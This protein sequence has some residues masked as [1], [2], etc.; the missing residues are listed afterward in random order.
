MTERRLRIAV[1][2][3]LAVH[4]LLLSASRPPIARMDESSSPLIARLVRLPNA[5]VPA[6]PNPTPGVRTSPARLPRHEDRPADSRVPASTRDVIATVFP[7]ATRLGATT[8]A[9]VTPATSDDASTASTRSFESGPEVPARV[10]MV[11]PATGGAVSTSVSTEVK[12]GAVGDADAVRT[13]RLLLASKA[14]AFKRYPAQAMSAGWSGTSQVRVNIARGGVAQAV[15]LEKSSGYEA[16]DR[17]A[18]AMIEAGAV[19]A[20]VPERLRGRAFVV[21]LPVVFDLDSN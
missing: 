9:G 20:Q 12:P 2:V 15:D 16:L 14:R 17:A 11:S 19:R 21:T 5:T 8:V 10:N 3:S 4:G 6:M 1:L 18:I 7:E 13:Y